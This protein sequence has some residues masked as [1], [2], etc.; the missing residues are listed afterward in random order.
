MSSPTYGRFRRVPDSTWFQI[1]NRNRGSTLLKNR[2]PASV[3]SGTEHFKYPILNLLVLEPS[4]YFGSELAP[5][6][7]EPP[8][9]NVNCDETFT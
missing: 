6:I 8:K 2:V 1:E 3:G 4:F 5:E 9:A 7:V